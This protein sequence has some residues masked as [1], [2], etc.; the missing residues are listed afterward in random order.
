MEISKDDPIFTIIG[1]I[2]TNGEENVIK[3]EN[4]EIWSEDNYYNFV[5]IMKNEGYVE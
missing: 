4:N 2:A 1:A 5:N 3:V